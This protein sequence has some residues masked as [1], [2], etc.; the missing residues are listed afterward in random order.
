M[1]PKTITLTGAVLDG[2]G[3]ALA[4]QTAGAANLTL[5]GALAS[6]GVATLDIPRHVGIYCAGDINTVVFTVTGTD[7]FGAT[8][9]EDITGVNATT[10]NGVKNFKTVTQV[11]ADAAVGTNVEV[12]T[13]N[14]FD[15]QVIPV[16]YR[17]SNIS[18]SCN[19]TV[20]GAFTYEVKYTL[21]DPWES[22]F[23]ESAAV[24]LED[25]GS[26]TPASS[27]DYE[28]SSSV[29]PI[30]ALRVEITGWTSASDYLEFTVVESNS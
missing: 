22:G 9:T 2:N 15:S 4:Q 8:I 10:V 25:L 28:S 21:D 24:W 30:R 6:G 11:A 1:R 17:T 23:D 7:R 3:I 16:S 13:T 20:A 27:T 18:Y 14:E 12:G 29:G 26:K 19:P 5:A